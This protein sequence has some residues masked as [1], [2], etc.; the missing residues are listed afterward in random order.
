MASSLQSVHYVVSVPGQADIDETIA[1][2][3]LPKE[4]KVTASEDSSAKVDVKVEGVASSPIV[5]RLAS[6]RFVPRQTKLLRIVLDPRC[7]TLD[8]FAPTCAAPLTCIAGR[9]LDGTVSPDQLEPYGDKWPVNAPDVC[10][11]ANHGDPHVILG[12]GQ[13]DFLPITNG[14]TVQLEKGPQG[15]H[16]IWI[17]VRMRNLKQSGSTTTVT[18]IQPGTELTVPPTGVIFTFDRDEGGYCKQFGITFRLDSPT[19]LAFYKKFLGKPL[20]VTVEVKDASGASGKGSAH[21]N[22]APLLICLAGD[23]DPVCQK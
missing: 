2:A 10:K 21:V 20:D 15:G 7:V 11:P 8:P 17:A 5:T 13:T 19:D 4:V 3:D 16:H 14:Q 18:A 6:T 12:T 22:V 9:C 23:T 1:A